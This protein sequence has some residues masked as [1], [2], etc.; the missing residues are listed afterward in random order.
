MEDM[1]REEKYKQFITLFNIDYKN[2]KKYKVIKQYID[3]YDIIDDENALPHLL[4]YALDDIFK[5]LNIRVKDYE[6]SGAR[7]DSDGEFS[8]YF[9][10]LTKTK[11]YEVMFS[12]DNEDE[13]EEFYD[14]FEAAP[15]KITKTKFKRIE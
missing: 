8:H 13:S 5:I 4:L 1:T 12:I 2:L 7:G 10:Q 3:D 9:L 15:Y 14:M 6:R 11:Y